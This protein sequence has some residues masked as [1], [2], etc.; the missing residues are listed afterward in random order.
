[1]HSGTETA[2]KYREEYVTKNRNVEIEYPG[3]YKT[4]E[5]ARCDIH[6]VSKKGKKSFGNL[7]TIAFDRKQLRQSLW[8][9]SVPFTPC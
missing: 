2:A 4:L 8:L 7:A 6:S 1:M 9:Q 5:N 3:T